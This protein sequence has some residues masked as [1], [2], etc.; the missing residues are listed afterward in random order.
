MCGLVLKAHKQ[1]GTLGSDHNFDH[2]LR[3]AQYALMIAE[4]EM[5]GKLGAAAA[6]CHSADRILQVLLDLDYNE[7]APEDQV[8]TLLSNWLNA[9]SFSDKEKEEIIHAVLNHTGPNR[10]EDSMTLVILK[11][12]DRLTCTDA[13]NL[14]S[15]VR[16]F[17]DLP[18]LDPVHLL[19]D[20][21]ATYREPKSVFRSFVDKND[22][23]GDGL[24]AVRLSKAK[25]LMAD[26]LKF[27]TFFLETVIR[28]RA[29]LDLASY[30]FV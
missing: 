25:G 14:M 26:R 19:D 9:E 3:A 24:F 1:A 15:A 28:Q 12:A 13:E 7:E 11:D 16:Y 22:W 23:I 29:E 2:D 21:K 10:P 8:L 20:P 27:F 5:S 6:L 4:D 17:H 18:L 30:P